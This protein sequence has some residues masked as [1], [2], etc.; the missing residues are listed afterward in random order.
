VIYDIENQYPSTKNITDGEIFRN[1]LLCR[2][3]RGAQ[4]NE[5]AWWGRLTPTKRRVLK[6]LLR[7][8][9]YI[10]EFENLV[11]IR[12]LWPAIKLGALH[13]FHSLQCD[14]VSSFGIV[15]DVLTKSSR[16]LSA[17]YG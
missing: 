2:N 8:E 10:A 7:K 13:R 3:E 12:G 14:E 9:E 17:T 16:K 15:R 6:Q 5:R 11:D 4:L 1:I